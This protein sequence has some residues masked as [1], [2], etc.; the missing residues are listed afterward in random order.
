MRINA[1]TALLSGGHD[2]TFGGQKKSTW[3]YDIPSQK[4][5][6]GPDLLQERDSL[7]FGVIEDFFDGA[8]V[9]VVAGGHSSS[10]FNYNSTELL[11]LDGIGGS[12]RWISGPGL[13]QQIEEAAGLSTEDRSAFL[14]IGGFNSFAGS[15]GSIYKL[16]CSNKNC[17]WSQ[18]DM[19]MDIARHSLVAFLAPDSLEL[20]NK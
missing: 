19:K 17:E 2:A 18:M 8:Q 9:V 10:G 6:V 20:C 11:W 12:T 3:F 13:P 15:I 4:W 7:S 1:T 14:L 16:Q 5:T